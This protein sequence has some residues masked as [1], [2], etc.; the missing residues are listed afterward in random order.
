MVK[1]ITLKDK[2]HFWSFDKQ[3]IYDLHNMICIVF[4]MPPRLDSLYPLFLLL[5]FF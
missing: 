2:Q 4:V 1:S 5:I 3:Y